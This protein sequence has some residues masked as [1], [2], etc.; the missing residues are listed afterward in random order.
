MNKYEV[1]WILPNGET[2]LETYEA[3]GANPL[4]TG[5]V[6][7]VKRAAVQGIHLVNEQEENLVLVGIAAGFNSLRKIG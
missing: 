4:P 6:M 2:I 3:E 5:A 1:K 7:F